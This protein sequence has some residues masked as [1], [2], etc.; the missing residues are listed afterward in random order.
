[1]PATVGQ[2]SRVHHGRTGTAQ[3]AAAKRLRAELAA[4]VSR[5]RRTAQLTQEELAERIGCSPR[6]IQQIEAG[7]ANPT[8]VMLGA[9]VD[10][11][12]VKHG[13]DLFHRPGA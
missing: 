7:T 5:L 9:L 4:G 1:M 2:V 8:L 10:A 12:G 11:L 13:R 3:A 6:Y